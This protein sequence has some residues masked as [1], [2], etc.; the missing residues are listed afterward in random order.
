MD[1]EQL[2]IP[3]VPDPRPHHYAFAHQ[4]LPDLFLKNQRSILPVFASSE[5]DEVMI[6]LWNKVG[7]QLPTSDVL[8]AK[9]LHCVPL[10]LV[11]TDIAAGLIIFPLTERPLEAIYAAVLFCVSK[12]QCRYVLLERSRKFLMICEHTADGGNCQCSCRLDG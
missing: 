8:D 5:A 1:I 6:K 9:G 12:E 4:F 11:D 2:F 10:C 3:Q 7:E